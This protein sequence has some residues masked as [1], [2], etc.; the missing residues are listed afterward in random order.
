MNLKKLR[1]LFILPFLFFL[2]SCSADSDISANLCE[3]LKSLSEEKYIARITASFPNREVSFSADYRFSSKSD[4]R[5]TVTSPEEIAGVS[6]SVSEDG[7]TLEFDGIMLELGSFPEDDIS[8]LSALPSLISVWRGGNASHI[9]P[10]K[11]FGENA[12]LVIHK[13]NKREYRTW[14][15]ETD[16]SPL[17]AEIYSDG[18]RIIECKFERTH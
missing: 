12:L 16:F 14:F 15:S 5:V 3:H 2:V 8:P 6:F 1:S 18:I 9:T 11:M 13:E 7:N 17:Y 10:S 4:D